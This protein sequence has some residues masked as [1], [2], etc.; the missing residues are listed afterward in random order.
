MD[1]NGYINLLYASVRYL[2]Y[3]DTLR[4]RGRRINQMA[5]LKLESRG[6][7][8]WQTTSTTVTMYYFKT[9]K[10]DFKSIPTPELSFLLSY[11]ETS[12]C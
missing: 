1:I 11:E 10:Q 5:R 7:V 4:N 12:R 2:T 9:N 3:V 6:G 8:S